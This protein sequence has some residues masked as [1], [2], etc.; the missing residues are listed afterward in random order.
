MSQTSDKQA[1]ALSSMGASALMVVMKLIVGLITGSL[2]ILSE[3]FHS[4]LDLGTATMTWGAVRISDQPADEAHPYG[5]GKFESISALMGTL[6]LFMTA[7]GVA[8]EAVLRL[9]NPTQAVE[10]TWYGVAVIV[11]S[12]LIDFGRSRALARVAKATGSPA[13]EA[14][15]LH[16]STDI[17][18]SLVV[19]IGLASVYW[20]IKWADSAAA[21]GVSFFIAH[22]GWEL[23]SRA[24]NVLVDTAPDGVDKKVY[25]IASAIPGVAKVA[26]V[27]ARPAGV[28][29]F[30]D[31]AINVSR[32]M[33]LDQVEEVR[34]KIITAITQSVENV[35]VLVIAEP[36]ALDNETI[37]QTIQVIAAAKGR[38]VH[39]IEVARINDRPH[40]SFHLEVDAA[41]TIAQAHALTQ[42]M[43]DAI[44]L[45]LGPDLQID[46]H[47]D[48][49]FA[50][51]PN[52]EP[53]SGEQ[54]DQLTR[55]IV[56]AVEKHPMVKAF[57][58]IMAQTREDGL[59]LSLHC[60]FQDDCAISAVHSVTERIEFT[61]RNSIN[62]PSTVVVHAEP[63]SH[64]EADH[65]IA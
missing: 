59:Y 38:V 43:E 62:G 30:V 5:H 26:W 11:V 14:D 28:A 42:K 37:T 18:S 16:F 60:L 36:L 10:V 2:G 20:G 29:I 9:L 64:K 31:L 23:G 55:Q 6:L 4:G 54:L 49:R 63:L 21:L 52:G 40:I 56:A 24:F 17:L 48:P 27:R 41:L 65:I 12:I 39:S 57:H 13:L 44:Y 19:L 53:V 46:I 25:A 22:A 47:I 33:P 34:K 35:Q 61:L 32:T 1:V 8:R 51:I 3:A 50:R 58:H 45:E 7:I 15:A